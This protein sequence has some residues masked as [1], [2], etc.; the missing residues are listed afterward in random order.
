MSTK[1]LILELGV[2]EIPA[3]YFAPAIKFIEDRLT[4]SLEDAHLSFERLKI[5]SA[6]RR[7]GLGLWG[8]ADCQ[9]DINEE[10]VGPPLSAAYD[11]NGNPTRAATG[12]ASGQMVSISDLKTVTTP[13]GQYLSIRRNIKGR[14]AS[15][16]LT[17]ILPEILAAL[18]FPKT[19][20]WGNGEYSFVRPVHWLLAVLDGEVLP[21]NF[22]GIKAGKVSYGHRFLH[23][24]AMVITSPNEYETR[25]AEA[26]IQV[27]FE[28]RRNLV[29]QEIERVLRENSVDLRLVPDEE[30]VEEVTNLL[31]EPIAVMGHFDSRF[32]ELPLAVAITAMKEHQRYFTLT[33]SQ[34]RL[35][36]YFIA[37]NNIRARNMEVVRK[38][39]ERVLRARL[40]DARFY[41][42]EDRKTKLSDRIEGLKGV[43]FHNL[44]GTNQQ[45]VERF[46]A[47]ALY[48]ADQVAPKQQEKLTRAANLCKCDLITGVVKEFPSL[49]GLIGREYARLDGEDPQVAEAIHEHYLPVRANGELPLSTIGAIL[50]VADKLDTICGCFAVGL[51]PSGTADPFA[52][53]RGALGIL[54]ILLDRG[55]AVSLNQLI[56]K[57]MELLADWSKRPIKEGRSAV[58]EFIRTRLK[59]LITERGVST[60]ATEAVLALYDDNPVAAM[61]RALALEKLKSQDNFKDLSQ[62]FKRVINII[63]KFGA[64]N[65]FSDW[66]RLN[67][68]V[69]KNI[70]TR[71]I[72]LEQK[73]DKLIESGDFNRLINELTVLRDPV[74]KF[75]E[76]VLVDDPDILIKEARIALLSRLNRI[77]ELV[78]DFSRLNTN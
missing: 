39:H 14:M 4:K 21:I 67:L 29:R 78:A 35:A 65:D 75:F 17:D 52:L 71:L 48:L 61:R 74:D 2:E 38:G 37:I 32:L 23:P 28:K 9:P 60:D 55:W 8:L 47:L 18:P 36:P 10:I 62:V 45:K 34:G 16:V 73:S 68:E 43:I 44:L 41:F 59:G 24:G 51:I 72:K 11:G 53:R 77:F 3:S 5:W 6:P 1:D 15:E 31:E 49:Q 26:H 46:K 70:L 27:D 76:Q 22:A 57:S 30:L 54:N 33:D 66:S 20:H 56:D 13:K 69:E 64:K 50:S 40:D 63:K 58:A 7:L 25:L 19:M 12:F 42:T